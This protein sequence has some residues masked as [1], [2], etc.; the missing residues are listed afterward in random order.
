MSFQ[1]CFSLQSYAVK[2]LTTLYDQ[3]FEHFHQK[4][5]KHYGDLWRPWHFS[6]NSSVVFSF[7]SVGN[8]GQ[9][10]MWP[11]SYSRKELRKE[12]GCIPIPILLY[13]LVCQR[14]SQNIVCEMQYARSTEIS[15]YSQSTLQSASQHAFLAILIH[16]PLH[17]GKYSGTSQCVARI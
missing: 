16:N 1:V 9:G 13:H 8:W 11:T 7:C 5:K 2:L 12:Y 10:Q 15:Y 17:S 3:T 6:D 4:S 14:K